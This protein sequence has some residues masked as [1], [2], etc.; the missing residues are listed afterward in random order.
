MRPLPSK[1]GG[2]AQP[3]EK[4]RRFAE[5]KNSKFL[6][7]RRGKRRERTGDEKEKVAHLHPGGNDLNLVEAENRKGKVEGEKL[8]SSSHDKRFGNPGRPVPLSG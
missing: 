7:K 1:K 2:R 4:R 3:G 6:R 5:K 8:S